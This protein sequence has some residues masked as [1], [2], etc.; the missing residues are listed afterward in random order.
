MPAIYAH[1]RFG[2]KVA[3]RLEGELK[4]TVTKYHAPFVIGLQGPDIFFFY[5]PM[6]SNRVVKYGN[7]LHNISAE[8]FFRHAVSVVRKRGSASPEYAY[9]M[10]FICHFILD[11]ECHPYV[12]QMIEETGVEHL[13]IEEE[14]EKLLLRMDG[15]DAL[16]YPLGR[17]VPVD[18]A[19]AAAIEP[20]YEG[21]DQPTV[22]ES[23]K[24][25]RAIKRLLTAPGDR[26]QAVLDAALHLT[27][28]YAEAKGLM[29]HRIDNPKCE[30]SNEGL[31]RRFDNAVGLA[32][33]MIESF[34]RSVHGQ[35]KLDPRFDRTFE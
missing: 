17:L 29:L 1:Y 32:V 2:A 27:G 3:R 4:E 35:E 31:L 14:F 20:F 8:P 22:K 9:L 28:K 11:S 5:R 12:A 19:T 18:D 26:K 6:I 33:R 21:I 16:A 34:D 7:H 15:K 13:E 25:M 30:E 24:W 23:L 10:G